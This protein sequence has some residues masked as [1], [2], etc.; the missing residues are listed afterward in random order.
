MPDPAFAQRQMGQGIAIE[1]TEGRVVA[2][3]DGTVAHV[4][5]SKHAVILQHATGLQI[6]VH[7]GIDTV[8]LK[9]SGFTVHVQTG[10]EVKAGQLLIEFD[11]DAIRA[12]GLP[13]ITPILIPDG[14][15]IVEQI[16][17]KPTGSVT[18]NRDVILSIRLTS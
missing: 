4:I 2:P 18:I 10:D 6:L 15:E 1:P 9:G 7:V 11:M 5:K 12:A 14:Q 8:S 3:F 17:E 13:L 16:E